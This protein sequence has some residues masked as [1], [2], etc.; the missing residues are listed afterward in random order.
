ML[1]KLLKRFRRNK[2]TDYALRNTHEGVMLY[3]ADDNGSR[4]PFGD[5][6]LIK[7][8]GTLHLMPHTD[9]NHELGFQTVGRGYPVVVR[10]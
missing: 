3:A 2:V 10:S 7:T 9:E 1:K 5:I 4:K 8:D 6:L